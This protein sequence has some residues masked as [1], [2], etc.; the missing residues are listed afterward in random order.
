[1]CKEYKNHIIKYWV[2]EDLIK[3]WDWFQI[4]P[5]PGKV[6]RAKTNKKSF[7]ITHTFLKDYQGLVLG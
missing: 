6:E 4:I 5:H 7:R 1:M 2:S 3:K